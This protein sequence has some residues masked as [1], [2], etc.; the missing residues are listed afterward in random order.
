MVRA[1]AFTMRSSALAFCR[2]VL[3]SKS[4]SREGKSAVFQAFREEIFERDCFAGESL[5]LGGQ[6]GNDA[7]ELGE[8]SEPWRRLLVRLHVCGVVAAIPSLLLNDAEYGE[9]LLRVVVVSEQSADL[10]WRPFQEWFGE[11]GSPKDGSRTGGTEV[12]T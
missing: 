12:P 2:E 3:T 9:R 1:L 6:A 10:A 11:S 8:F 7:S 4:T 5:A